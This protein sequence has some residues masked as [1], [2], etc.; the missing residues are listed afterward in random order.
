MLHAPRILKAPPGC[1]FSHL[2]VQA[3]RL[4]AASVNC[5]TSSTGVR[6][7]Q[8]ANS[9]RSQPN[10]I[11]CDQRVTRR[12]PPR[13]MKPVCVQDAALALRRCVYA[14]RAVGVRAPAAHRRRPA[15][16]RRLSIATGGTGGV[17]YPYGGGIAKVITEHLPNTEATA[18]VTAASV[19]NLKF[20]KQ[21]NSDLAFTMADIAQ[22]AVHGTRR[23]SRTSA[24][25]QCARS[26]CSIRATRIWWHAADAGIT[27]VADLA[28]THRLHWAPPVRARR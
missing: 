16:K 2:S 4:R 22:D 10:V 14:C 18:E 11:E 9:A 17:F 13:V 8:R 25:C 1:R 3:S 5:Y 24:R 6:R 27:G 21:G 7:A 15:V 23:S 26:P 20:L 12:T 28:R 19:D